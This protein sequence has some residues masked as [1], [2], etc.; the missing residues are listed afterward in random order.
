MHV[1]HQIY[2]WLSATFV[3]SL[4]V[5][6]VIG[7][8]LFPVGPFTLSAG[9]IPFPVT[10]LLTDL[11][12]EYYGQK[13]ARRVT[14]LGLAMALFTFAL[15][16]IARRLPSSPYSVIPDDAFEAVFGVS[17]RLYVASL[18]AYLVGQLVDISVFHGLKRL[19][20]GRH[21]W[22]RATGSTV[23]S[24]AIDSL[25]VSYVL[26]YGLPRQDG[27]TP[28]VLEILKLAATGYAMKF[29]IAVGLTPLIYA[30]HGLLHSRFQV[31]PMPVEDERE[32]A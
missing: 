5:A 6:D 18:S 30:G 2:L 16:L 20:G 7:G 10:F 22:L 24:Q 26:F 27:T 14:Y 8:R 13:A 32:V 19:T 23:V 17:N 31:T 21:L 1:R 25:I 29:V 11:L 3:T 4:V 12:N 28:T 9:M 15:L